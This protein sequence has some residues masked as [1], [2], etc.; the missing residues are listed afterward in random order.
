VGDTPQTLLVLVHR[1][2]VV[3]ATIYLDL[4]FAFTSF[5]LDSLEKGLSEGFISISSRGVLIFFSPAHALTCFFFC[6][7]LLAANNPGR[8]CFCAASFPIQ[9]G[10]CLLLYFTSSLGPWRKLFDPC[11]T[12]VSLRLLHQ[13]LH[14]AEP[15][16]FFLFFCQKSRSNE[17]STVSPLR[18]LDHCQ[19]LVCG[20]LMRR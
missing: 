8:F 7:F 12:P 17:L 18:V 13:T 6:K 16:F 9:V 20:P 5:P 4:H 1:P 11:G 19:N 15:V 14:C 2:G 10:H 3:V